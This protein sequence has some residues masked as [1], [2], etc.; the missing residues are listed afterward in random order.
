[1]CDSILLDHTD[2]DYIPFVLSRSQYFP[3]IRLLLRLLDPFTEKD[4]FPK[5]VT[6]KRLTIKAIY[7][8]NDIEWVENDWVW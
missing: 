3:L 4:E 8:A 5:W 7:Q 2:L 6:K 1:M